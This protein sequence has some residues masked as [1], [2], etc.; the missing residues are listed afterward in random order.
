MTL[1]SSSRAD[2]HRTAAA[3]TLV[4]LLV[5]VGIVVIVI[6]LL[7]SA[8]QRV[9]EAAAQVQC[10]NNLKQLGLALHNYQSTYNYLPKGMDGGPA[11]ADHM[12]LSTWMLAVYPFV[13]ADIVYSQSRQA[14][15][16]QPD[17]F[18]P[19]PHPHVATVLKP[20]TC[21]LDT[22]AAG[23]QF[24][25]IDRINVALT[26][27]LGVSGKTSLVQDGLLFRDSR[28]SLT[29]LPRGT[30]NTL[31]V[32]ERPASA[33]LQ[34]GWW[35]AGRGQA[36]TGSANSVLGVLEPNFLPVESGSPCERSVYSFKPGHLNDQCD[37]FHF[38]SLHPGGAHFAFADGAVRF[39]RYEGA[40]L[41]PALATRA[42]GDVADLPD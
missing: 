21:P 36:D 14:Y 7:F 2:P 40:D 8:V 9:R 1:R 17:P 13:E 11:D 4:E 37:M 3:F 31:I 33:D 16:T 32:G 23:A 39:V 35:Y 20:Y 26:D 29:D 41:L 42:G 28:V 10:Q 34:F 12:Y 22:R 27:Y 19:G 6:S 30:S 38:W 24:V 18:H 25:P 15:R 5:V